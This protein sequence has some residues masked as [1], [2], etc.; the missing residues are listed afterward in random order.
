MTGRVV[1]SLEVSERFLWDLRQTAQELVVENHAEHLKT[2]ARRH[3]FGLSIEPYDMNPCA[4]LSLGGVADVPMCEFWAQG[5]GFDT[6][7]SCIEAVSIAHTLGRPIVAAEAFTA[8]DKEAW[9]LYPGI[10]KAQGDW[11][12]CIGHQPVRLPSLR[13]PAV[14][15]PLAGHDHGTL[16]RPLGA[17]ADLVGH[18]RARG[19]TTSSAAST[20]CGEGCRW[21]TSATWR[22][23][24]RRTCSARRPRPCADAARPDRRGYNF[25]GCAAET[26]LAGA[27]VEEWAAG[28]ARRHELP[29]AGPAGVGDDDARAART[30]SRDW[31]KPAPPWSAHA[32]VK[33]PS[34]S[35][36]PKCDE[37]V[38]RL[39]AELWGHRDRP[40]ERKVG[41]GRVIVAVDRAQR[42]HAGGSEQPC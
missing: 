15:R 38:Q 33:S 36:Y 34:L 24:V 25:D 3:G 8:D 26:L 37:E 30:R 12:F 19:T 39:A 22:R 16:R 31:S 14:A 27:T 28:A 9:R 35:D 6:A 17:H 1:D 40:A 41:K 23:K 13:P 11:A 20:C 21:P 5:Y 10:M 2:L 29:R 32:R 7:F 4:D 18:G 42:R